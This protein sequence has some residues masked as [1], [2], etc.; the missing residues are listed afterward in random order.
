MADRLPAIIVPLH[1]WRNVMKL[2][3]RNFLH[4]AAGAAALPAF[5]RNAWA[6]A[7]PTRPIRMIVPTPPGGII[8]AVGRVLADRMKDSLRQ[9]VIVENIAGADGSIAAGRAA[10]A[11][12]DGYT[13]ELGLLSTHVLNGALYSLSYDVLNDFAPIAPIAW[14]PFILFAKKSLAAVDLHELINLLKSNSGKTVSA[15]AYVTA[16]HLITN[17]FQHETATEFAVVPYRGPAAAMQDLISGQI[18]L[19]FYPPDGL[20]FLRA[21]NVKA[22]AVTSSTRLVLAPDVPTFREL[23]FPKLAFSAWFGLFGPRGTSADVISKLNGAVVEALGNPALQTRFIELGQEIYPLAQQTPAALD[24]LV[25]TDAAKWW[26]IV[27]ALNFK[28][29]AP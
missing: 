17:F 29:N 18:D 22:Y 21:G 26:P 11:T 19:L 8:D 9:P 28:G 25:R 13:I 2:P 14:T 5:S 24:E 16:I 10:R 12:P 6:Q 23:N 20:P 7:Y 3:R 15:G 4:L 27:K 1:F